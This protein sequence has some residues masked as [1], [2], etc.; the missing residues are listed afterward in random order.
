VR[1]VHG[2]PGAHLCEGCCGKRGQ[3][4]A[5]IHGRIGLD[6]FLDIVPLCWKCHYAYDHGLMAASEG[7][8]LL[9][10]R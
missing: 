4:W 2:K 6:L 9:H 1:R 7:G 8:G 5:R 3:S 10:G